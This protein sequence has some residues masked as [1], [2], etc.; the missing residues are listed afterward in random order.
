VSGTAL[1]IGDIGGTNARFAL[2]DSSG[3]SFVQEQTLACADYETAE[4]AIVA[5][6]AAQDVTGPPVICLAV[7]GPVIDQ[8]VRFTNN[9]W[10]ID[11]A[12]LS[13]RFPVSAVRLLN[14]FEAIAYSL[15]LLGDDDLVTIGFKGERLLG[16][17]DFNVSVL[18]PGTG[19]GVA[20][21]IGRSGRRF[22]L[23]TEGGHVGFA[24]E[25]RLQFEVLRQLRERFQRVSDERLLCGPGLENIY[26]AIQKIHGERTTRITA[27]EIFRRALD[28]SDI[29]ATETLNL[30][31]EALGQAAGNVALS[32]GAYDGIYIGGGILKRYPDLLRTS[33]FR[34]GF[35]NKGRYRALMESIPTFL[36]TH[37][38]PG[39]LGACDFAAQL[40]RGGNQERR[41]NLQRKQ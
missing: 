1:L 39:L 29:H 25:T 12:E 38:E 33:A 5:Y 36:I 30:F 15:P 35:E 40:Y 8:S 4:D 6:L 18:G 20:G 9:H 24:P 21:L 32:H 10:S 19:L 27:P 13:E 26:W 2:A 16:K 23:V 28:S 17:T 34:T 3:E 7:A 11:A 22:A 31:Y 37:S 14:D 41:D